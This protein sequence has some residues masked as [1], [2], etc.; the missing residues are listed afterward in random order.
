[1]PDL[2]PATL[3]LNKLSV[4][5]VVNNSLFTTCDVCLR[6]KQQKL[7]FPSLNSSSY[8]LFDLIHYDLWGPYTQ[9]THGMCNGFLTIVE[10]VSKCT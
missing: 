5:P 8:T 6:A 9:C 10:E 2:H 7:P 1:M 3:I 4:I